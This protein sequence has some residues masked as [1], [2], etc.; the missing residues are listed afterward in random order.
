M[1][2]TAQCCLE[3][4][5]MSA[6]NCYQTCQWRTVANAEVNYDAFV[7]SLAEWPSD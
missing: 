2:E 6:R 4:K 1:D 7:R 3:L 5:L